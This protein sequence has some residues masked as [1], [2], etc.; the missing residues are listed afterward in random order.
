MNAAIS[1]P[2][3]PQNKPRIPMSRA[4][5]AAGVLLLTGLVG[6]GRFSWADEYTAISETGEMILVLNDGQIVRGN[7]TP[8][9]LGYAIDLGAGEITIP[10]D[11]VICTAKTI[12]EAYRKQREAMTKPTADQHTRLASWCI[13]QKLFEEAELELNDALALQPQYQPAKRL[14]SYLTAR[15]PKDSDFVDQKRKTYVENYLIQKEFGE[16]KPLGELSPSLARE[17]SSRIEPLLVNS[18]ANSSCHGT[19]ATNSFQLTRKWNAGA[20]TRHLTEANLKAVV[21]QIDRSNPRNSPLI[22]KLDGTHGL[23]GRNVFTGAKATQQ[24]QMLETWTLA[25][26]KFLGPA[27]ESAP[28]NATLIQQVGFDKPT[29]S[30]E[31]RADNASR[32]LPAEPQVIPMHGEMRPVD[33]DRVEEVRREQAYDPFDPEVFNR[34]KHGRP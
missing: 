2:I 19:E 11:A 16:A 24:R 20:N 28:E 23:R 32:A 15:K 17:F 31:M 29:D 18:C 9:A 22:A 7:V 8:L 33:Q 27:S 30:P 21:A 1:Q 34:R 25:V 13:K 12:P 4:L 10:F 6:I 14:V 3:R 5:I 26:A